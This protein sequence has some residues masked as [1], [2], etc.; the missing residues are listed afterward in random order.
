MDTDAAHPERFWFLDTH[1]TV[2]LPSSAGEDGVSVLEHRA[3]HGD[4]PPLHVHATEDEIFQVLEGELRIQ[5]AGRERRAGPGEIVL[6][7]KRVAHSYRVESPAGCR[8]LTTTVRGDFER[9]VRA[10]G[11]PTESSELPTPGGPPTEEAVSAL[12]A[13]VRQHGIEIVGPP[14]G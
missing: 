2:R 14:L 8:F 1:V 3:P 13:A 5:V 9:L 10:L 4:S 12:S 6:A 7:P 11:R